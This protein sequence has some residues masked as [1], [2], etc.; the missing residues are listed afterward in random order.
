MEDSQGSFPKRRYSQSTFNFS[1]LSSKN[2]TRTRILIVSVEMTT[3]L[4][5]EVPSKKGP[6]HYGGP[7]LGK[8]PALL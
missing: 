8:S 2:I 7:F 4:L 5:G 6:F 1:V 3:I